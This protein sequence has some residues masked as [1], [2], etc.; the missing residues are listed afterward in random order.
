ME[1][2]TLVRSGKA[3]GIYGRWKQD[4]SNCYGGAFAKEAAGGKRRLEEERT[5]RERKGTYPLLLYS[6]WLT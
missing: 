4:V 6:L 3:N 2:E 5:R 1:E